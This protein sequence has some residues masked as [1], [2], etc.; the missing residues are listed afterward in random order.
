MGPQFKNGNT[1]G[2]IGGLDVTWRQD[3]S[4]IVTTLKASD[5]GDLLEGK[6]PRTRL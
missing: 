1:A 4:Q 5:G 3:G 2:Q 6:T